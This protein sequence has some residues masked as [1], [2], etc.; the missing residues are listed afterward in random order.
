[1]NDM[2]KGPATNPRA[3][4]ALARDLSELHEIHPE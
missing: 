1:M 4:I 2:N 3:N